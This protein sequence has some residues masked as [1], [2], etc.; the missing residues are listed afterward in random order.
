VPNSTA[1]NATVSELRAPAITRESVSRPI[2]SVPNQCAS[3]G[4]FCMARK[5]DLSAG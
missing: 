2:W 1:P 4:G 3:D 5:S